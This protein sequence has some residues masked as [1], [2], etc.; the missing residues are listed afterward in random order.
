MFITEYLSGSSF[1][2]PLFLGIIAGSTLS[3]QCDT[4]ASSFAEAY[5]N[6]W[7]N[8]FSISVGLFTVSLCG[9]LAAV[10]L[11]AEADD[12]NDRMR[13]IRKAVVLTLFQ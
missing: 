11:I 5:L 1:I 4:H 8:L 2:T 12:E 7:L 3:G 9:F 10:Y 6:G 13:F